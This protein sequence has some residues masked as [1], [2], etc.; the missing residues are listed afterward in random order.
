[1]PQLK[2]QSISPTEDWRQLELLV[3]SPEQRVYELIW[4]KCRC[5][6]LGKPGRGSR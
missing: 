2:R 5:A 1:M 6:V 4:C 3:G